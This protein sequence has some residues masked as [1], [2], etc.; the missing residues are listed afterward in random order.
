MTEYSHETFISPFTWRY[1][2]TEMREL[3][4]EISKRKLWRRIWVALASAQA[5]VGLVSQEQVDDLRA[6]Q[7][8]IDWAR[9]QEIERELVHDLVSEIRAFAEKCPVGGGIIHLGATSM[10]VEDNA[11]AL[12]LRESMTLLRQ[13]VVAVLAAFAPLIEAEAEAPLMAYT[14]LQPAEPTTLGYRLS[15]YALTCSPIPKE[16]DRNSIISSDLGGQGS[17]YGQ[18]HRAGNDGC[19]SE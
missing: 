5:K 7:D 6:H 4:S 1:G 9:A 14:H 19:R 18:R 10:D 17:A 12:R 13:R 3:W 16:R 8:D 15:Q 11:D 2:S